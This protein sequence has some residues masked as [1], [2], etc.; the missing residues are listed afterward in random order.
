[1]P[2]FTLMLECHNLV[3]G[4]SQEQV[5]VAVHKMRSPKGPTFIQL[6]DNNGN[7]AQAGGSQGRYRV[8]CRDVWGEGF[9]HFLAASPASSDRTST[10]VY[11]RNRCTEGVHEP[12]RC[13]LNCMVANVLRLDDVLEIMLAYNLAGTRSHKYVWDDVTD[14]WLEEDA[15]RPKEIKRIKPKAGRRNRDSR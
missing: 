11:Y 2:N 14:A 8:E 15:E 6:A 9:Q 1:M 13:P 3:H 10:V 4:A 12:R 7:Y 5:R